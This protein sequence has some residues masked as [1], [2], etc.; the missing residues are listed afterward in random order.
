MYK[1]KII[2]K[3]VESHKARLNFEHN[4]ARAVTLLL[5]T[6]NHC[7][8]LSGTREE[9]LKVFIDLGIIRDEKATAK[10][11]SQGVSKF[12]LSNGLREFV[13]NEAKYNGELEGLQD[14]AVAESRHKLLASNCGKRSITNASAERMDDVIAREKEKR[15]ERIRRKTA[16]NHANISDLLT[17]MIDTAQRLKDSI[18]E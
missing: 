17:S 11:L 12:L 13:F 10:K 8:I 15:I 3:I 14:I 16:I 6:C 4:P 5:I 18:E 7:N 2:R 1:E 9:K